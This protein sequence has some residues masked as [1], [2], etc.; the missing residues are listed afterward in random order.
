MKYVHSAVLSA[1][2]VVI[3]VAP[4]G[5]QARMLSAS[6]LPPVKTSGT[7]PY[8]IDQFLSPASPLEVS[9][10]KRADRIAWVSY[11]RG[12]RNI[13]VASAPQFKPV[14][15]TK[16]T[17]DD[18]VDIGSVRLFRRRLPGHL[19]ARIRAESRGLG[20]KPISRSERR[21]AC[22]VGGQV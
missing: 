8:T 11:E 5:A 13:Y 16:F 14:K 21:R 6:Q 20:G 12:V 9:A 7:S 1:A 17:A 2:A 3:A 10:A 22:R 19:R 18:G 15:V 4:L